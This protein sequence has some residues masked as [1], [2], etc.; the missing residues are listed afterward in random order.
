VHAK[1]RGPNVCVCVQAKSRGAD[2]AGDGA[3][4]WGGHRRAGNATGLAHRRDAERMARE[5]EVGEATG[6]RPMPQVSLI[7]RT[8]R[9]SVSGKG[10]I[11]RSALDRVERWRENLVFA[12]KTPPTNS[13]PPF[14]R[15]LLG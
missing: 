9:P 5:L 12:P 10:R 6:E 15:S 1:S 14:L 4:G 3:G 8:R 2:G 11:T 13:T 7:A